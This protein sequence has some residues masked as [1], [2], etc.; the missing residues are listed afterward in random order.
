METSAI[1]SSFS[2]TVSDSN[3]PSEKLVKTELDK[4]ITKSSSATGLLKDDGNV[5]ASG[6]EASNWAVGNHTHGEIT[7]DGKITSLRTSSRYDDRPVIVDIND[8]NKIKAILYLHGS[9]L[10]DYASYNYSNI[11]LSSTTH[12]ENI[13]GAINTTMGNKINTS[14]IVDNLTTNDATKPLSAKQGKA[15]ADLIGNAITYINGTGSGN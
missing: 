15:L 14:D 7:T 3:I 4:K 5:M 10:V 8:N 9:L 6:T 13:N 11:G 2:S 12:Q 1:K